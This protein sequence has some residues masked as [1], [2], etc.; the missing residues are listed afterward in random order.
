V[1]TY[2]DITPGAANS[3][4]VL[5]SATDG[6]ANQSGYSGTN[7]VP[8]E[9]MDVRQSV[10]GTSLAGAVASG[11][12]T[13]TTA[14]G[15]RTSTATVT[16]NWLA[17]TFELLATTEPTE[18]RTFGESIETPMVDLDA[19]G[20]LYS[21]SVESLIFIYG[22]E[23]NYARVDTV[24]VEAQIVNV[25]ATAQ[26]FALSTEVLIQPEVD[27]RMDQLSIEVLILE[28][29]VEPTRNQFMYVEA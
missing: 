7:P 12:K 11:T 4:I 2:P 20:R 16:G 15:V 6:N 24:N 28:T 14:T 1:I 29:G 26:L 17:A 10:S 9:R 8:T 3:E 21:E 18:G 19:S 23:P 5:I 22:T 13:D 25:D 27:A